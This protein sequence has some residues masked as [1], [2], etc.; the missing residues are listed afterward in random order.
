MAMVRMAHDNQS[1]RA[2]T[3]M[4]RQSLF[5][6]AIGLILPGLLIGL[7]VAGPGHARTCPA[8]LSALDSQIQ[9]P[10]LRARLSLSFASII[11]NAGGVDQ[12]ITRTRAAL[13][14]VQ[15]RRA[16]AVANGQDTQTHDEAVL[17]FTRQIEALQCLE[18][19]S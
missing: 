3:A 7:F 6:A 17:I 12:A 13:A 5:S 18:D 8:D 9:T 11:Q 15:T 16:Q 14:G 10:G 1:R 2:E 4:T 19:A